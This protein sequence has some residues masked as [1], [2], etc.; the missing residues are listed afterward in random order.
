MATIYSLPTCRH[1]I[2]IEYKCIPRQ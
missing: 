2:T 1:I